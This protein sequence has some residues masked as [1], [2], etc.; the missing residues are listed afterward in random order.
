MILL[1]EMKEMEKF[2]KYVVKGIKWQKSLPYHVSKIGPPFN[3]WPILMD[4][5]EKR[6]S[7]ARIWAYYMFF[8]DANPGLAKMQLKWADRHRHPDIDETYLVLGQRD[9]FKVEITLD[10][11]V[12]HLTPPSAAF[13][14]SGFTHSIKPIEFGEGA[15]GGLVA[16]V[17]NGEYLCIPP[18]EFDMKETRENEAFIVRHETPI[19]MSKEKV[20]RATMHV[21]YDFN[22]TNDPVIDE[23]QKEMITNRHVHPEGMNE[24]IL[25]IGQGSSVT[26]ELTLENEQFQLTPPSAVYIPGGIEHELQYSFKKG[27]VG[28]ILSI[29]DKGDYLKI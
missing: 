29:C 7:G 25:V 24:V 28:G 20:E 27:K 11:E 3:K 23:R 18:N 12:F 5:S 9:S 10:E 16:T 15:T 22:E 2:D 21:F 14:P 8:N 26:L 19:L 13:I 6:V 4:G 17:T 1:M